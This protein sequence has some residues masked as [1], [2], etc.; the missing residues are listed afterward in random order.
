LQI[1]NLKN[2]IWLLWIALSE[3]ENPGRRSIMRWKWTIVAVIVLVIAGAAAPARSQVTYSAEEG[4]LP[5]TIGAGFSDFSD[6]WGISNPRQVGIT[7]WVDWR[8]PHMPPLLDGLGLEFEGR[9]INYATP[10]YI[11]GHRM[12][13]ALGGPIYQWRRKSRI[14]PFA[15][16]ALGIGSIDFPNNTNYQH[17]TRI[18]LEPGGGAD[19]RF[20]NQFS[21]RIQYDYQFWHAIFGPHDLNPNGVSAGVVYD[22]GRS[23]R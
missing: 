15:K 19:I 16:Y 11:P 12:D 5:F 22:F 13:T 10:S 18:V 4:K 1:E 9:D 2:S 8:L 20:W 23:S 17:D 21:A 7:M 6:D 3:V 14:R